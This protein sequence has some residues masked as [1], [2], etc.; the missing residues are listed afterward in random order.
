M[1]E[2]EVFHAGETAVQERAGE[3]SVAQ[4]RG[5]MLADR[6][7]EGGRAFLDSQGHVAV[8]AEAQDGTLW[9][10]LWCGA[11]GFLRADAHGECVTVDSSI[12][13]TIAAD[14][15][16]RVV[17]AG[18]PLGMLAIDFGT[19]R[20]LRVNGTVSRVDTEGLEL[21]VREVFGNCIKYV[22]RRLRS[23]DTPESAGEIA[24]QGTVFDHARREFIART[25]TAFV[26]SVHPERGL[27]V[28]HRGG[29]PGFIHVE[30]QRTVQFPDYPGNSMFQTLGNFE[31]DQRAGL[32]L[33]DFE[34]RRVL[35]LTGTAIAVFGSEDIRSP[36]GGTGRY[37]SFTVARW[38]EFALPSTMTWMLVE[39]SPFNPPPF[40]S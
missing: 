18:G 13:H 35:S 40:H 7:A 37:W 6:I 9:A 26:A 16:R 15:V 32:A 27:D 33:I 38:V 19:R 12:D 34:R 21:E 5:P 25:D 39:P 28:S 14:P 29:H 1:A 17:R 10:S 4:R 36:T 8:A 2:T 23:D 3:R 22:Q 11:P 30:D 20:R 31:V 24:K